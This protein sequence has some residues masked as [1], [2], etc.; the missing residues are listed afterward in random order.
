MGL[1][2]KINSVDRFNSIVESLLQALLMDLMKGIR[3]EKA[4]WKS[5]DDLGIDSTDQ[6]ELLRQNII[7]PRN[8]KNQIRLNF[9]NTKLRDE[10]KKFD[11]QFEQLDCFLKDTE[12][13]EKAQKILMQIEHTLKR[14]SENWKYV[15]ALGW[16]RM[17]EI[18][19]MPAKLDNILKEGFSPEDWMIKAP[20]S[21]PALALNIASRYGKINNFKEAVKFLKN[22]DILNLKKFP[23]LLSVNQDEVQRV[24]KVLRWIEIEEKLNDFVTKTIGFIWTSFF[25]LECNNLLTSSVEFS[26]RLYKIIW[27]SLERLLEK[28]HP[29]LVNDLEKIVKT[30]NN[31]EIIWASDILHLPEVL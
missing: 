28:K 3:L 7:E 27:N 25:I 10:F 15:I 9:R 16:W 14:T 17:L 6:T 18:S 31:K 2:D 24:K 30:L 1:Q 22:I 20:R 19:E 11:L 4:G 5:T 23:L 12:K 13:I 21:S 26:L 8:S 29:D